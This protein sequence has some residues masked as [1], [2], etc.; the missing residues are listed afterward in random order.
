MSE[1]YWHFYENLN[2][3]FCPAKK[4]PTFGGQSADNRFKE[5]LRCTRPCSC[6]ECRKLNIDKAIN[7]PKI[8]VWKERF[9][10]FVDTFMN[11][12]ILWFSMFIGLFALSI[13]QIIWYQE[14]IWLPVMIISVLFIYLGV[15][16]FPTC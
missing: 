9:E 2:P 14:W 10:H 3:S 13:T 6:D 16:L 5:L 11:F 4:H 15:R 7:I 8:N 1:T 12:Y